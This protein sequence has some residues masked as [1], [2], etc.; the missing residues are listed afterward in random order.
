MI[1]RE[2]KDNYFM[3]KYIYSI[4]NKKWTPIQNYNIRKR[5]KRQ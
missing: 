3:I 4:C 1:K 5:A 2:S